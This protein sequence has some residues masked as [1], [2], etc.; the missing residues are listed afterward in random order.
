LGQGFARHVRRFA[1]DRGGATAVIFTIA[2][3]PITLAAGAA[4]DYSRVGD[5]Q[6]ALQRAVDAGALAAA[7]T[8]RENRGE[9]A[10]IAQ[11]TVAATFNEPSAI[12]LGPANHSESG[13]IHE[14]SATAEVRMQLMTVVGYRNSSIT[15]TA[16]ATYGQA[17]GRPEPVEIAIVM[18]TTASMWT[19]SRWSEAVGALT[20]ML[21]GLRGDGS[22]DYFVTLVPMSDRVNVSSLP[23]AAT[24]W[25]DGKAPA[26][27]N[28]CLEPRERAVPGFPHALD[29]ERPTSNKDKFAPSAPGHFIANHTGATYGPNGVPFCPH[30]A[31]TGPTSDV[32]EIDTALKALTSGGTGRPDEGMAWGWRVLSEGWQGQWKVGN[33]YPAKKGKRRKLAILVTD[34]NTTAYDFEVGGTAGGSFGWNRG[35]KMGF[36]HLARVCERMKAE[37]IEIHVV[38]VGDNSSFTPYAR[39]CAT[40]PANHYRAT[41]AEAL[42]LA[43]RNV[44]GGSTEVLRLVR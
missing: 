8:A 4:I 13:G 27:W 33:S 16:R 39:G 28:G 2:L 15:A 1:G 12:L 43:F 6:S 22:A 32:A 5:A 38:Q 36:D 3:L 7:R 44:G 21:K 30:Q 25:M 34:G 31:V 26:N 40:T 14:V 37:G 20:T 10:R 11:G 23:G 42:V 9:P 24:S 35:S 41:D 29:D 19:G 18:D 17:A